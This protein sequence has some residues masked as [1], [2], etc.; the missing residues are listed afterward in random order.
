MSNYNKLSINNPQLPEGYKQTD[1][2]LIPEDWEVA[3]LGNIGQTFIGLT[4]RPEDTREFGTLVLRSSNIQNGRL[5][6]ENNVYINPEL[7]L[8]SRVI[9]E[10]GD[11]LICV[12]NGSK[13]LIGKCALIDEKTAG[14]AFGAFMSVF[15]TKLAK[16][17]FYQ[18]QSHVIQMQ[19]DEIMGAT[20]NQITTKDLIAFQ[21]PLPP[22]EK[23][24]RTIAQALSDVDAL[25]AALDK[26]IV[27]KRH[28]KTATMQ[29]L[30]TGKKRLPGFGE[31]KGYKKTDIGVIPEDWEVKPLGN[32]IDKLESGISVNSTEKEN[33]EFI[34]EESVLKTSSVL[35]GYFFPSECKK[36]INRDIGRAKI[37]PQKNTIIISRMNT[38]ALVGECGYVE[39]DYK[40]LFLPD[41]LWITRFKKY[42]D[43]SVRWLA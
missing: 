9:V 30:L 28:I 25:I 16:F 38:P 26:L 40:Y 7:I 39:K 12:R 31:G 29:Q 35:N 34:D 20:I 21:I 11:I 32:L 17:I 5:V 23:E 1:V 15:R 6:Y 13:Q 19:I 33:G 24:Q 27:K 8:P 43:L 2:G 22:T 36:I 18:F 4:Y 37:N 41:R 42:I 10:K 3:S 14:C